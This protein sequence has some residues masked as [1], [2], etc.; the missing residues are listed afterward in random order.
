MTRHGP[1]GPPLFDVLAPR[2]RERSAF[3]VAIQAALAQQQPGGDADHQ[4]PA[5]QPNE[6]RGA[7][8]S[9]AGPT[10]RASRSHLVA[11]EVDDEPPLMTAPVEPGPAQAVPVGPG[12]RIAAFA[13]AT[14]AVTRPRSA[15]VIPDA[16][17]AAASV[18]PASASRDLD[19]RATSPANPADVETAS[20]PDDGTGA[21]S[22]VERDG[23]SPDP[24]EDKA[25]GSAD[26]A[27]ADPSDPSTSSQPPEAGTADESTLGQSPD[28]PPGSAFTEDDDFGPLV[29]PGEPVRR[30]CRRRT[31]DIPEAR[32]APLA[33]V[34]TPGLSS[35]KPS[36]ARSRQLPR[37]L[38]GVGAV[39]LAA[40]VL[41][42]AVWQL[43]PSDA[44][45]SVPAPAPVSQAQTGDV[46]MVAWHGMALPVSATAG[47]RVR[48]ETVSGFERS[49]LGAAIA[50]A[51]LVVRLDPAAGPTVFE[52]TLATQV[53]GDVAR[54]REAVHAQA[55]DS[56]D[57][58]SPG[59]LTGWRIESAAA[60][61]ELTVHLAVDPGDGVGLDFA[62]PLAWLDGDWRIDA[63]SKGAFFPT[64]SLSGQYMPFV[65]EGAAS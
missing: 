1:K 14:G 57:A 11:V 33:E 52:P 36:P 27:A 53:V 59:A 50:A 19:A 9:D 40:T 32:T 39:A 20:E 37:R 25:V 7:G 51:N 4:A 15:P 18:S 62:V 64:S 8:A 29:L 17:P 21:A 34:P 16:Q 43:R 46:T 58:G 30:W 60:A 55:G 47:P 24:Q 56:T 48:G 13:A 12:P 3:E 41:G 35:T 5:E 61:D 28:A 23:V 49:P 26:D 63:T 54:L 6:D 10:G 45:A 22:P 42:A 65:Q 2:R 38:V 44:T 31:P